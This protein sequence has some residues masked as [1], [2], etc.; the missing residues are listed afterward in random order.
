MD[1]LQTLAGLVG[2]ALVISVGGWIDEARDWM[3]GFSVPFNPLR[4]LGGILSST[5]AV[6][7]CVGLAWTRGDL[8]AGG[9]VALAA[10]AAD[11]LLALMH[12]VVRRLVPPRMPPPMT[13]PTGA[14]AVAR[15]PDE[16]PLETDVHAAM[17]KREAEEMRA[18]TGEKA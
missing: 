17:D 6:G 2:L 15:D 13:M 1:D 12:G 14:P 4:V 5:M 16:P 3:L 8:L 7:F 18:L 9:V 10:T 11:E